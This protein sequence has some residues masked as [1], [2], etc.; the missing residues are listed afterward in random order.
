MQIQFKKYTF[1]KY[2]L[3]EKSYNQLKYNRVN[4]GYFLR[5][6]T[7]EEFKDYLFIHFIILF[8]LGTLLFLSSNIEIISMFFNQNEFLQYILF[9]IFFGISASQILNIFAF[10]FYLLEKYIYRMSLLLLVK[11]SPNY[12]LFKKVMEENILNI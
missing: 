4:Y 2:M 12:L 9:L 3:D 1:H 10:M 5:F 6:I 11:K 7:F 8:I